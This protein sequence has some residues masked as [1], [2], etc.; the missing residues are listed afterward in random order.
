MESTAFIREAKKM[1]QKMPRVK[2]EDREQFQ[3][4]LNRLLQGLHNPTLMTAN[5]LVSAAKEHGF[6]VEARVQHRLAEGER[7]WQG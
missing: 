2:T 3:N 7:A 5:D 1:I 6:T 4:E